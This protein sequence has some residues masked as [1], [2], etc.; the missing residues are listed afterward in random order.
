MENSYFDQYTNSMGIYH[1]EDGALKLATEYGK[2]MARLGDKFISELSDSYMTV[3]LKAYDGEPPITK[4]EWDM[5][6]RDAW[7]WALS[8]I[9]DSEQNLS[10]RMEI[11]LEPGTSI[12]DAL[13]SF[14]NFM[15]KQDDDFTCISPDGKT[16]VSSKSQLGMMYMLNEVGWNFFITNNTHPGNF[17]SVN[18]VNGFHH[19]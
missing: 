18:M 9:R 1:G 3:C 12:M 11:K 19:F 6:A 8:D 14:L 13:N 17:P 5:T 15:S 7:S 10:N 2:N 16:K 4:E